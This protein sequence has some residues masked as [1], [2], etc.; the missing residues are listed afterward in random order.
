MKA[1][2]QVAKRGNGLV[3]GGYDKKPEASKKQW[4]SGTHTLTVLQIFEDT[5]SYHGSTKPI[6]LFISVNKVFFPP[7]K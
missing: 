5:G 1:M 7:H 6:S 3:G 2:S 4:E